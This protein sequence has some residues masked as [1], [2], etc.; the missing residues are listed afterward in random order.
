MTT[1]QAKALSETAT[2]QLIEA[3]ECGQSDMLKAYLRIM[4][5]FHCYS[6]GNVLLIHAQRPNAT[7]VAG[8]YS[9][10]KMRRYV[11][12]GEK[13]I[14]I[15]APMMGRKKSDDV[16]TEDEIKQVFGFRAAHVFDRLSRDFRSNWALRRPVGP[17]EAGI[18]WAADGRRA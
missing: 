13:G 2:G 8:F 17:G 11:R 5:R 6:W 12:K 10:V 16:L 4:A 3:L 7:H 15:L 14:A 18:V 1:E 9:W